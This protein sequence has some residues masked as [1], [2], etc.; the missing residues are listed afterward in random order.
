M[1]QQG[2]GQRAQP[3]LQSLGSVK[4]SLGFIQRSLCGD[5]FSLLC[6]Q[7]GLSLALIWWPLLSTSPMLH[8]LEPLVRFP[9]CQQSPRELSLCDWNRTKPFWHSPDE[10]RMSSSGLKGWFLPAKA[11][12]WYVPWLGCPRQALWEDV[13][14]WA[15]CSS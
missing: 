10:S 5:Q 4:G 14:E 3:R 1:L 11:Q 12:L 15:T 8:Y 9:H 6:Q 2:G 7:S 13:W